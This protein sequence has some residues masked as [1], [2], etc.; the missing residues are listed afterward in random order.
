M[1]IDDKDINEFESALDQLASRRVL[2]NLD[3]PASFEGHEQEFVLNKWLSNNPQVFMAGANLQEFVGSHELNL[4]KSLVR[5]GIILGM[6]RPAFR[7]YNGEWFAAD[8]HGERGIYGYNLKELAYLSERIE[9]FEDYEERL[10]NCLK[11]IGEIENIVKEAKRFINNPLLDA[12]TFVSPQLWTPESQSNEKKII[13]SV[14]LPLL[15]AIQE[16]KIELG[17]I[18]WRE[19]ESIVAEILRQS[20]MEISEV[21]STPQGGRDIIAR[22]EILPGETIT[23]AIEV[24]HRK[25]VDRPE[26]QKAL[27]QNSHFPAVMLITSGRF[28]AGVIK[29]VAKPGNKMRV[30]LKDGVALRDMIKTYG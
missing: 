26:L 25:L 7:Q 8:H 19:L 16:Q 14:A 17:S 29:E 30:F 15:I 13:Q 24:K 1:I 27:Y 4:Y 9:E 12:T 6:P 5:E 23:M 21:R 20:G 22:T 18:H 10:D 2:K 28:T 11:R 3:L